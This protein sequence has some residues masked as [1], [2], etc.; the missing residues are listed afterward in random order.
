MKPRNK[1]PRRCTDHP[2][3]EIIVNQSRQDELLLTHFHDPLDS[4]FDSFYNLGHDV[5]P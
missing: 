1:H 4:N 3:P 2:E 5:S